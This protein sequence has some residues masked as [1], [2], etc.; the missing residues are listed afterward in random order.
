MNIEHVL[1]HSI[2]DVAKMLPFL[3]AAY[4][5]IEYLE[6][7]KSLSIERALAKGG[8]FGFIAGAVLGLIPQCGF[9]AAAANFYASRVVSLGTLVAVFL[10]TSDEAVPI[11]LSQ[12]E[13][14][15]QMAK[16][17]LFKFFYAL[18]AGFVID[19]VFGKFFKAKNQGKSP[20]QPHVGQSHRHHPKDPLP[21]AAAKHTATVAVQ[22]F[23]FTLLFGFL[24]QLV[25][26]E[27]ISGFLSGLG[28][29]QPLVAAL[30]GL[31]PNCAASILLTQLYLSGGI[32][33]GSV[34]AGLCTSGGVGLTVLFRT[35]RNMGQN[36]L[37]VALLLF[38]GA[39]LGFVVQL[40]G[41]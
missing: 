38:L 22:I 15:P 35:N 1:L 31:V 24:V 36:V 6:Q 41:F 4:V 2:E 27:K 32:G 8:R 21:L 16:L 19:L 12:P 5:F 10:A 26:E 25:G 34:L 37:I 9:S 33:F 13:S 3:F 39:G 20:K 40:F 30:F 14:L 29:L 23:A 17:L 18:F 28:L 11:M 7:K